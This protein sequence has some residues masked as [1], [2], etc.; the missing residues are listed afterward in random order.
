MRDP[1]LQLGIPLLVSVA[2]L[3]L[4]TLAWA[5][6]Q[7]SSK[8][9]DDTMHNCPQP[10]KWAIAVWDGDDGTDAEQALATCNEGGVVAAYHLDPQTQGWLRWFA[11]RPEISNLATLDNM[12]G[13]VAVGSVAMMA[14]ALTDAEPMLFATQESAMHNCPEPEKWAIAVWQGPD[15]TDTSQAMSTC[16]TQPAT[17]AYYLDPETQLWSRWL[18][19]RPELTTLSTLNNMQGVIAL[20]G[21]AIVTP[22]PTPAATATLTPMPTATPTSTP[23][24][25]PTP[26]PTSWGGSWSG[27]CETVGEVVN[28]QIDL[29][30][31][32][33]DV[34]FERQADTVDMIVTI[35]DAYGWAHLTYLPYWLQRVIER[36]IPIP[37]TGSYSVWFNCGWYY[38]TWMLGVYQTD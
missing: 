31:G 36:G 35:Q 6:G 11:G 29:R 34:R 22:T 3:G 32:P 14:S 28:Q 7:G 19:G 12:Q 21:A 15:G 1:R 38:G 8:A 2:V 23:T 30:E 27:M 5:L 20:G 4:L 18:A 17:L 16:G 24:P 37:Y 10:D 25:T 9:Q 33:A 26:T 13:V